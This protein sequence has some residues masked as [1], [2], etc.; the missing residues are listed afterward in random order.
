MI[1][2]PLPFFSAALLLP[3]AVAGCAQFN[4]PSDIRHEF[5]ELDRAYVTALALTNQSSPKATQAVTALQDHW[6]VFQERHYGSNGTDTSWQSDFN[7]VGC[8]IDVA[9]TFLEQKDAQS[10][11]ETLEG[12]RFILL[13]LRRRHQVDY[14]LDYLTKYHEAME[15]LLAVVQGKTSETLT[16]SDLSTL[17]WR[18]SEAER[19]WAVVQAQPFDAAL[20]GF[21]GQRQERMRQYMQ[22]ETEALGHLRA[23]VESESG[24][25]IVLAAQAIKPP[26]AKL[27]VLFGNWAP[28]PSAPAASE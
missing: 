18:L 7:K 9:N 3:I 23:A 12:V 14:Y 17:R 16:V 4:A 21:D 28:A 1:R 27:F 15:G 13:D 25:G 22:E 8:R 24:E 19:Q 5:A 26:F 6:K 11:H 20:Y 2:H 10:A